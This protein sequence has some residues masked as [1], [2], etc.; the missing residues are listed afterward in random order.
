MNLYCSPSQ[1]ILIIIIIIIILLVLLLLMLLLLC[2]STYCMQ[3][4][5]QLQHLFCFLLPFLLETTMRSF[6]CSS[7]ALR[8]FCFNTCRVMDRNMSS[9]LRLSLAD[10]SNS[11]I[12]IC[13]AKRCASSV[14]T[15]L[16]SGSSFL[17][18]TASRRDSKNVQF[19]DSQLKTNIYVLQLLH[20]ILC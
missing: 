15:T 16:R 14:I 5:F 3:R 11:S 17:F 12:S 10:V 20:L 1:Q 4:R 8:S 18:P 7:T 13:R 9:T 19:T 2:C 6:C